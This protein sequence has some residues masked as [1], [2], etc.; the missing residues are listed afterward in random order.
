MTIV[1]FNFTKMVA[2]KSG[3]AEGKIS[4]KNNVAIKDVMETE[5]A[6]GSSKQKALRFQFE[7]VSDY[8]P[9]V[10]SITLNGDVIYLDKEATIK[11]IAEEWKKNKK[12]DKETT[13]VILNHVLAKCNVQALILSKDINLPPPIMLPKVKA[14]E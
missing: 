2:E 9:K 7:F 13:E 14:K 1:G 6:L 8:D 10:G 4:I 5:L 3:P 12:V 11:A